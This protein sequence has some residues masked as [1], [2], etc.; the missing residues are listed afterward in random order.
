M[1][2]PKGGGWEVQKSSLPLPSRICLSWALSLP[3][4]SALSADHFFFFFCTYPEK[5]TT[6]SL[7]VSF[8]GFGG[9]ISLELR[10]GVHRED[11]GRVVS[12]LGT[13]SWRSSQE[14]GLVSGSILRQLEKETG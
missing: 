7:K 12:G 5:G 8:H 2:L 3:L 11:M 13:G 9:E 4:S 1:L 14:E 10:K 6:S